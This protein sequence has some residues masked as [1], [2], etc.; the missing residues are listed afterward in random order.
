M[1]RSSVGVL[2]SGRPFARTLFENVDG[3]NGAKRGQARI[4]ENSCARANPTVTLTRTCRKALHQILLIITTHPPFSRHL[5]IR[6]WPND[7]R[8]PRALLNGVRIS[9]RCG[10]FTTVLA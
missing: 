2:N 3:S 9:T 6:P 1:S 10:T 8:R 5:H 4:A 7:G